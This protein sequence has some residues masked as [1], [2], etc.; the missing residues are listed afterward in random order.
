VLASKP[1]Y[2]ESIQSNVDPNASSIRIALMHEQIVQEQVN[3][4]DSVPGID[5]D[6]TSG[7]FAMNTPEIVNVPCT[8]FRGICNLLALIRAF[9]DLA[10]FSC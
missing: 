2:C 7:G 4:T 3:V 5:V 1:D 8:T 9:P 6:Q 10:R